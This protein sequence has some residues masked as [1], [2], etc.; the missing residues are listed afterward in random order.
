MEQKKYNLENKINIIYDFVYNLNT[1]DCF[2]FEK[3]IIGNISIDDIKI[4]L[5]DNNKDSKQDIEIY[6]N[7]KI[8]ILNTRFKI[9]SFNN[10]TKQII[11]KRYGDDFPTSIKI[12]FYKYNDTK[13]NSLDTEINNDSLLSYLLSQL[14]LN[15]QTTHILL[16][17]LNIDMLF[18]DIEHVLKN[19]DCYDKIK[20]A[21]NN[22]EISNICCCQLREQFFKI[23][24]LEDYLSKNKCSHKGLIF[25]VIHTLAVLQTQ[26]GLNSIQKGNCEFYSNIDPKVLNDLLENKY[27]VT[28]RD[29]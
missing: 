25:Q 21:I 12:N 3:I 16:P 23:M 11:L 15:K 8:D 10:D 18:T 24:V 19:D 7:Y 14:I 4:P 1:T 26:N 9:T 22:N 13:I 29:F 5:I 27:S 2:S 28:K 6:N 20:I 17:I